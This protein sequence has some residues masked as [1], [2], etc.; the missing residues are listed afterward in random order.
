M[1]LVL[2]YSTSQIYLNK[3]SQRDPVLAPWT[4][5]GNTLER[6]VPEPTLL[7]NLVRTF[8]SVFYD[9]LDRRQKRFLSSVTHDTLV[10]AVPV[11]I[12]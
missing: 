10:H 12:S 2:I 3:F 6:K 5:V 8:E 7:T 1:L 4:L 9:A 11:Q